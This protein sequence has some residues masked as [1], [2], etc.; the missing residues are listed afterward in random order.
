M[1]FY[2]VVVISQNDLQLRKFLG[3]T[4]T[5]P[6]RNVPQIEAVMHHDQKLD[7]ICTLNSRHPFSV[8]IAFSS[9]ANP[10]PSSLAARPSPSCRAASGEYPAAIPLAVT[11][12]AGHFS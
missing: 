11:S 12:T 5:E 8:R 10:L 4:F 7:S 9:P 2:T 1:I 3:Q 6:L